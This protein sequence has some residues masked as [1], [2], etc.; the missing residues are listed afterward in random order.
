LNVTKSGALVAN[1][2][3]WVRVALSAPLLPDPLNR[4]VHGDG[5]TI[6]LNAG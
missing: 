3:T 6:E 2:F 1:D 5:W 4:S